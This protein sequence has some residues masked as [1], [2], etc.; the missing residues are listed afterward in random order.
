MP[1]GR[2]RASGSVSSDPLSRDSITFLNLASY[3]GLNAGNS[4]GA[5]THRSVLPF[6][7]GAA[8]VLTVRQTPEKSG[9]FAAVPAAPALACPEYASGT[10]TARTNTAQKQNA[11]RRALITVTMTSAS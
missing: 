9:T 6:G 11:Y 4:P 3:S 7:T 2:H 1:G 5:G 8:G 10:L